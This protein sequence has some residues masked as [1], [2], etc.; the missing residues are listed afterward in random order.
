MTV[1]NLNR[2]F[3]DSVSELLRQLK[4]ILPKKEFGLQTEH[5]L[6]LSHYV[7]KQI[8]SQKNS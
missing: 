8:L 2:D 4:Y 7:I 3:G 6:F 5:E 1:G